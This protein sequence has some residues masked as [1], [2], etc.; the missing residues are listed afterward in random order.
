ME[1]FIT[2]VAVLD[3][4]EGKF[5]SVKWNEEDVMRWCQMVETIYVADPDA[6]WRFEDIQLKIVK[7]K[8]VLPV[9]CYKLIDVFDP[10][11]QQ[12]VRF[13]RQNRVIKQLINYKKD[14]IAINY[15][16]TP[17][18]KDCLPMIHEDHFPACETFCKINNF[19]ELALYNEIN[20]GI[21]N[22]WKVRFDG[23]I[24]GVKG[25]FR[26][27]GSQEFGDMMVIHGNEIPRIGFMPLMNNSFGQ[28]YQ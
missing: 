8:F 17:I 5:K 16:G 20:Q 21:F 13:N 6:M 10:E 1:S 7:G 14:V 12:R 3:E 25:G 28:K 15:I 2:H 23:Q 11:T 24:Q 4:L 22:D 19:E 26:D 9:N 18:D 27:W